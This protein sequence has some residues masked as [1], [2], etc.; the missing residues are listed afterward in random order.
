MKHIAA[1]IFGSLLLLSP[2]QATIIDITYTGTVA[3]ATDATGV[4]GTRGVLLNGA[5]Y[6]LKFTFN[7][8]LGQTLGDNTASILAGGPGFGPLVYN[9]YLSPGFA[10]LT[11]N[12][13]TT[14]FVVDTSHYSLGISESI[15]KN[16]V[17][18]EQKV[19]NLFNSPSL[20]VENWV[21]A[22]GLDYGGFRIF[23]HD[24]TNG[25][26]GDY[27][28]DFVQAYGSLS[29]S[30]MVVSYGNSFSPSMVSYGDTVPEPA[31]WVMLILGF[32][33]IGGLTHLQT[34]S[35]VRGFK[36]RLA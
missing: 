32:L 13:R 8:S 33:T 10:A 28:P 5:S 27:Q 30:T 24:W 7:D 20:Y 12:G 4:F 3:D 14:N 2:A 15:I 17:M 21:V 36:T 18:T 29:P 6:S 9:P 34:R 16:G 35:K 31:T 1:G 19:T 26:M 22:D 25:V 23:T 11:I